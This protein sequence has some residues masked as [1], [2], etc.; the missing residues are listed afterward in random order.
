M[1]AT[2]RATS[3]TEL[4]IIQLELEH[5]PLAFHHSGRVGGAL[6]CL[7]DGELMIGASDVL[8]GRFRGAPVYVHLDDAAAWQDRTIMIGLTPGPTRSFSLESGHGH[9]F[10]LRQ[11]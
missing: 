7:P 3:K 6:S 2:I 8:I 10:V 1:P 4:L 11:M 5:G 9:R